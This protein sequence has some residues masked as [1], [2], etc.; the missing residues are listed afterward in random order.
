MAARYVKA[1]VRR[2]QLVAAARDVLERE[3]MAG[4]TLRAVA[5]EAGVPLGTVHYIFPSKEQLLRAVLEDVV[6][7]VS[8]A[9]RASAGTATDLESEMRRT[10]LE[11]WTKVVE[12]RAE[13]QLMQ[14]ELT[15]WALR[16]PGM[17]EVARWQYELYLE[18]I[19]TIWTEAAARAGVTLAIPADQL[20]R[21]FLGAADGLILQYLTLGDVERAKADL[22]TLV[23][24]MVRYATR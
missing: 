20:A 6:E 15:M 12:G 8:E 14:Y 5:A 24:Q 17:A 16:T 11:I 22:E 4:A 13:A 18:V 3:G 23:G 7:E 19:T 21:L 2:G 1:D 9:A 10:A